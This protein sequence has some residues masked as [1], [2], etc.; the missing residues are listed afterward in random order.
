MREVS[1][2][3]EIASASLGFLLGFYFNVLIKLKDSA[4]PEGQDTHES[5]SSIEL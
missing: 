5:K 1:G 3:K 4:L 2:G